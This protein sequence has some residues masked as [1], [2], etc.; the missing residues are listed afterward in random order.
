MSSQQPLL[1]DVDP[2]SQEDELST[3][4]SSHALRRSTSLRTFRDTSRH[5]AA[6]RQQPFTRDCSSQPTPT[7]QDNLRKKADRILR[8]LGY[9]S[10]DL[11]ETKDAQHMAFREMSN[12][13]Q[14][15]AAE[16]ERQAKRILEG[17][18]II[19]EELD[20]L[21]N[22]LGQWM[23]EVFRLQAQAKARN[24]AQHQAHHKRA[25]IHEQVS[26]QMHANL[27]QTTIEMRAR[28]AALEADLDRTKAEF[29]TYSAKSPS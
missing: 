2:N 11:Q 23:E 8:F 24:E 25:I 13:G 20:M 15:C 29:T 9:F 16:L 4:S 21:N 1:M 22:A 14:G 19:G 6:S 7:P 5:R 17:E 28:N 12:I 26:T 3:T 10:R 18:V 27:G